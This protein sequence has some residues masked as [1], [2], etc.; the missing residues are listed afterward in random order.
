VSSD[1]RQLS[2]SLQIVLFLKI[3]PFICQ[4]NPA[5]LVKKNGQNNSI[6]NVLFN[7]AVPLFPGINASATVQLLA[8]SEFKECIVA[9]DYKLRQWTFETIFS[10]KANCF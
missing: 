9:R 3:R 5:R 6:K 7:S 4:V 1:Q 2:T 8:K 10:L